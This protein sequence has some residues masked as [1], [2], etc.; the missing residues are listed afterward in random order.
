MGL[1]IHYDLS[2]PN[3]SLSAKK[4]KLAAIRHKC[5]DLPF[6]SVGEML[7]LSGDDCNLDKRKVEDALLRRFLVQSAKH[8]DYVFDS[9]GKPYQINSPEDGAYY[10]ERVAPERVIGFII[11]SGAG[12]E[13]V[14]VGLR[15]MPKC[16]R[17]ISKD[18]LNHAELKLDGK[19]GWSGH[20]KTQYA[21]NPGYGGSM[22]NF[23]RC[24]LSIVAMLDHAREL[25]FEL[26]VSDE[27]GFYE[28][29]NI[30]E[31]CK[32]LEHQNSMMA[33][34]D[35]MLKDAIDPKGKG[36]LEGSMFSNPN[37]ERLEMTGR[38]KIDPKLIALIS[39]VVK[40]DIRES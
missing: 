40:K 3:N 6:Q 38:G 31:L 1:T 25:G 28:S 4:K 17:G 20:C 15:L 8:V 35:G 34:F 39:Q 18:G 11:N 13:P 2:L 36:K 27:G 5:L 12:C 16:L 23:L 22:E 10:S 21:S 14:N 30:E 32:E 29:R 33:G 24:H 26:D 37:F 9:R 19:W 7:D